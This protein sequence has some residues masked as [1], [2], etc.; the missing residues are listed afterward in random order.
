VYSINSLNVMNILSGGFNAKVGREERLH[1][2]SSDNGVIVVN[3]VTIKNLIVKNT[4]FA[5]HSIH[6]CTWISPN[7]MT[8]SE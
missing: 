6:K 4:L 5:H 1:E 7:G 3:F 8:Q 2:S